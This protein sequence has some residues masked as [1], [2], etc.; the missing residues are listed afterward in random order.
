MANPNNPT[1]AVA[2]PADLLEI[3]SRAPQA[4]IL[5]DEAYF[6]FYGKTL[7]RDMA[8]PARTCLLPEHFQRPTDM[9]GFRIGMLTGDAEHMS[10]VSS[11]SSPYNVNG[12]ALACLPAAL[13][14]DRLHPAICDQV[15]EGR[16]QLQR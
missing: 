8:Q 10:M 14:D 9:A 16:E 6:E 12:V 11:V 7:L 4:A 1:G 15:R 3:A 13:A 2:D 5:V